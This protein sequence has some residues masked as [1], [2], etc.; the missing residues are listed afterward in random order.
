MC[1]IA[2]YVGT[3]QIDSSALERCTALLEHRGPDD[4]G[5]K[6]FGTGAGR[7]VYLVNRRLRIIDLDARA[8]QPLEHNGRWITYNG[9]LYN[10]VEVRKALAADGVTFRT[11]SD[12]EVLLAALAAD[13]IEA[14]D[15]CEGMW[16]FAM[17]DTRDRS[18]TLSRDRFG[19]K[20]LYL[21]RDSTGLYFAS[22]IKALR[23]LVGRRFDV[24]EQQLR[25]YL[26]NGYRSLYKTGDTFFQGVVELP[27]GTWL[28]IDADGRE[29]Q[30][31]YWTPRIC[32]DA[33]MKYD[34][35]VS[36]V[37]RYLERSIEPRLRADVPLA[38]CLSGGVDSNA[39]AAIAK[40]VFDYDVHGFTV[41]DPD[42]RYDESDLSRLSACALDIRHTEVPV[43]TRGFLED[44]RTLVR[45]HDGPVTTISY[46]V[47]WKLMGEVAR[48]GYRVSVSGTAADELF[49]GYYD[50]H[51]LF[52]HD[53]AQH[54]K[55][56]DEARLAWEANVKPLVRNPHLIDAD[57]FTANPE[58]RD[59]LY[60]EA[61]AF[62]ASLTT[63]FREPFIERSYTDVGLLRNRMLNELFEEVVPVILHEDDLNAMSFSIEN[64]S[65]YLDRD[66]FEFSARIPTEYLIRDGYAKA[67][68]RDAVRDL[69]PAEIVDNR[70]KIGFNASILSLL[71]TSSP[72]IRQQVLADSP[73]FD[74]VRREAIRPLLE[75]THLS[76]S[77]S[78]F[79]FSFLNAKLFLEHVA[80]DAA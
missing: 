46:F 20:P 50:H 72:D 25:R 69:L 51:L 7:H 44:L 42:P 10:Y 6:H 66:L 54:R 79:L 1:G 2:G 55:L 77:Q 28:R 38:F 36:G 45:R 49:T 30:V 75:A 14:L 32:I 15:S 60:L 8:R 43:T 52:L 12:T 9:E 19:E 78:K 5:V 29:T 13:G 35:A 33:R 18:L 4:F 23:V 70:R 41:V 73:V 47:H 53:V 34:D 59:H 58:F 62:A 74:V 39:L 65:P 3:R 56:Y 17:F 22:E 31:R 64:R 76:N 21:F 71:D 61:D 40:K 67:V 16:A 63:P 37:R 80:A 26:V 48:H 27:P 68:L 11:E 57:L 24:N